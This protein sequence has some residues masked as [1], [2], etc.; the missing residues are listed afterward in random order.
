MTVDTRELVVKVAFLLG[1][2]RSLVFKYYDE[3]YHDTFNSLFED[4]NAT[5][6]RYL[7]KIRTTLFQRFG[8]TDY[9]MKF[10]LSNL[11][12][13][14]WFDAENIHQL[15]EW[16][17]PIIKANYRCELYL[18]DVTGLINEYIDNCRPIFEDWIN[19]EYIRN[20]FYIPKYTKKNVLRAE[21]EKYKLN[22]SYYPFQM[23]IYWKEPKECGNKLHSDEKFLN[24]IYTLNGDYIGDR[25]KFRDATE[26]TKTN[27]YDF[28][29]DGY[30]I[31]IAVDCE[32]S[33]VFKIYG[34]LKNLN[35]EELARIEKI[36]LFDDAHTTTA[37]EWLGKFTK[38]PIQH[39]EVER[40]TELKSLVDIKMTAGV[41]TAFYRDGIDSFIICS[42]D[43]DFWG[44]ISSLPKANFL[45]MYE[46]SKCGRP[47]KEAL[48][49]HGIF[50]CAID[51]FFTGNA[52]ELKRSVLLDKLKEWLPQILGMNG[53]ELTRRLYEETRITTSEKEI[54][55][56]YNK[57]IKTLRLKIHEA[58]EFYIDICD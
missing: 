36:M 5:I 58:G 25:S 32:N 38:I 40:V 37:W 21:R 27:I 50:H 49:E 54:E 28:I 20:L 43:S 11:D 56:F 9:E 45:V 53:M 51:D 6:I 47:I 42:S 13:L 2:K 17:I 8:K 3:C 19:F 30:K 1:V 23:Y 14:E 34:V 16:G 31:A 44:L 12:R 41:C 39:I 10:N 55:N 52:T 24:F 29:R 48:E 7:C 15:E 33:D 4:R 26:D 35:Q 46:Y 18:E 57:Y 22:F